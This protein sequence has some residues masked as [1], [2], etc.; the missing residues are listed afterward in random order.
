MS[1]GHLRTWSRILEF[2]ASLFILY[3]GLEPVSSGA[4]VPVRP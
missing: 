3:F 1:R 4:R 2:A